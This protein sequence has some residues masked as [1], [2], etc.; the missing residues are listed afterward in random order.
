MVLNGHNPN[1]IDWPDAKLIIPIAKKHPSFE[2]VQRLFYNAG[3][4]AS[5]SYV[6]AALVLQPLLQHQTEQRVELSITCLLSLR[7]IISTLESKLE[8]VSVTAQGYNERINCVSSKTNIDRCTQTEPENKSRKDSQQKSGWLKI[9]SKLK[10]AR[11]LVDGHQDEQILDSEPN[12]H[13]LPLKFQIQSFN[14]NLRGLNVQNSDEKTR[15]SIQAI[16]EMKGWI[17]NGKTV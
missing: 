17:I 3:V 1:V 11:T 5:F 4:V 10:E 14:S 16:R 12:D 15:K 7:R 6:I 2:F 13:Y 8:N 9:I